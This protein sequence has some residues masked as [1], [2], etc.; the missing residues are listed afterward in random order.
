MKKKEKLVIVLTLIAGIAVI[1][2]ITTGISRIIKFNKSQG[3]IKETAV[4]SIQQQETKPVVNTTTLKTDKQIE[5][6]KQVDEKSKEQVKVVLGMAN[7]INERI[8]EFYLITGKVDSGELKTTESIKNEINKIDSKVRVMILDNEQIKQTGIEAFDNMT[9]LIRKMTI[10]LDRTMVMI[11]AYIVKGN[12]EGFRN[13]L[14]NI[15]D[16]RDNINKIID[17]MNKLKE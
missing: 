17:T 16:I 5:V 1:V 7:K 13:E 12:T 9:D 2:V 14:R 15:N 4:T 6:K 8:D 10:D 3:T 11:N